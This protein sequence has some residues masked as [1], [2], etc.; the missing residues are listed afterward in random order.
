MRTLFSTKRSAEI[1]NLDH[2]KQ[3]FDALN[4]FKFVAVLLM[5]E[6]QIQFGGY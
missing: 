6:D 5:N 4:L 2:D 3:F 1:L